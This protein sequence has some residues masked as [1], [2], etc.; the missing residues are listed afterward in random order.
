MGISHREENKAM[1][2]ELDFFADKKSRKK[3]ERLI[4]AKIID[5]NLKFPTDQIR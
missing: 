3:E 5:I 1:V 2:K 4:T